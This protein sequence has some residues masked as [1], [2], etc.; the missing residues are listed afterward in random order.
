M[1]KLL[2]L[3]GVKG[4]TLLHFVT[5]QRVLNAL[6]AA[7]LRDRALNKVLCCGVC[8]VMPAM[9]LCVAYAPPALYNISHLPL[10]KNC[11]PNV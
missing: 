6:A 8:T 7:T 4:N 5:G 9:R 1:V 10:F 2:R 11:M 3:E